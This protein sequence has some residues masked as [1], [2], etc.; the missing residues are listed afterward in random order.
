[1]WVMDS[2]RVRGFR[3]SGELYEKNPIFLLTIYVKSATTNLTQQEK[4]TFA[5]FV[6]QLKSN[7]KCK[8]NSYILCD[9]E[10]DLMN[11][12]VDYIYSLNIDDDNDYK[13]NIRLIHWSQCEPVIFN[14]KI[15]NLV[16]ADY[17]TNPIL[18]LEE[19]T[20]LTHQLPKI[21]I[22]I[23]GD[24]FLK[25]NLWFD[26][27]SILKNFS[28]QFICASS[29]QCNFLK[30]FLVVTGKLNVAILCCNFS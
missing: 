21:H 9:D 13:S 18:L 28:I 8:I 25:R 4:L 17:R 12:F 19:L 3:R 5:K 22:H 10:E 26:G 24:F 30:N 6:K 27:N 14:K 16:F 2:T 15:T 1:M 20:K 7:L 23:Y 11:K 29:A